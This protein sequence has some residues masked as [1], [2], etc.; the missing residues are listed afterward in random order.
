MFGKEKYKA[1]NEKL[2]RRFEEKK[3][4]I[5]VHRGVWCGNIIENT[6]EAYDACRAMGADL[7]ECDLSETTDGVLYMFH[8]GGE[9]RVL[10]KDQSILSMSSE[11]VDS[12]MCRNGLGEPSGRYLQRF[13]QLLE[14]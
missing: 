2:N 13:E 8:D 7:F 5:A 14:H 6:I 9:W 4:L 10:G 3:V 12:L 1:I 11:E